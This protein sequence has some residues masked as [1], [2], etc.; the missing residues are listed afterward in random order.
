MEI[1]AIALFALALNLDAFGAGTAYGMRNIKIPFTSMLIISAMSMAAITISMLA[2]H[3][4]ANYI[5]ETAAQRLGGILLIVIGIWVLT[6]SLHGHRAKTTNEVENYKPGTDETGTVVEIRIRSLGLAIQIL[7]E[8]VRAD[9]DRSGEI[10]PREALLLGLALSMDALGAGI[11]VSML[12]FSV[13]FT[14]IT[15]GLGHLILTYSGLLLGRGVANMPIGKQLSMIP[16]C[17]LILL[18]IFKINF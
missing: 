4:I 17:L 1:I 11:A 6:Q 5:P 8:P 3:T 13:L 10:S 7:K 15:V 9:L 18:G 12:G 16:G 14:A 2:G